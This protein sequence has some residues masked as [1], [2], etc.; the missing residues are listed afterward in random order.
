MNEP[1]PNLRLPILLSIAAAVV[2]IAMKS[3]AYVLTGSAGLLADALESVVNLL[4]AVA[5]FFSLW[6]SARPVDPTH[7]YGHEKVEFFS[8][9]LEGALVCVAG[10]GTAG[11]AIQR[12][13][14]PEPLE[15]LGL[16]GGIALVAAAVNFGVARYLL[17]VGRRHGSIVLEADG[18][19]IMTDVWSSV[20]VVTALVLV[21][22]TH[23]TVIDSLLALGVGLHITT[24]GFGL[25]RR[26]INGLMDHALPAD[27]Q[28]KLRGQIRAALPPG[29]QFHLLRTRQAGRRKF[30]DFHLLVDGAMTVSE[31]HD[32]S[33]VVEERLRAAVPGLEVATHI[34]PVGEPAAWEAERIAA[35]G[36]V[37]EP[38]NEE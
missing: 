17:R 29:A 6:Y 20:V 35:L 14:Y 28:E 21:S 5:A 33:E 34:E 1:A 38:Q 2:T 37:V 11:Y 9:G 23:W 12:L 32:L 15:Q 16:G 10:V 22:L 31:A 19:H 26:S 36:E 4:A 30:A 13:I 24:T 3:T 18:Q 8:S 27:E 7:A 25:V